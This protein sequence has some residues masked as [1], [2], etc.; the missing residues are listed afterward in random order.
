MFLC[1]LLLFSSATS[2]SIFHSEFVNSFVT[3]LARLLLRFSLSV[4]A[5][6]HNNF[7]N[8]V[9]SPS[10]KVSLVLCGLRSSLNF[11]AFHPAL[12]CCGSFPPA[13]WGF[14]HSLIMLGACRVLG[15]QFMQIT[16]RLII[17]F[18]VYFDYFVNCWG[19]PRRRYNH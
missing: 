7:N 17:I 14:R 4:F 5:A 9:M 6:C 2:L 13:F 16:L 1:L 11:S 18:S 10:I 8:S 15:S 19:D 12:G 3:L